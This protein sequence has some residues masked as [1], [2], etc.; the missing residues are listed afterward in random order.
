[1]ID[2]NFEHKNLGIQK[3]NNFYQIEFPENKH[4]TLTIDKREFGKFLGSNEV[5]E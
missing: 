2:P 3:I 5:H 1:M 4:R